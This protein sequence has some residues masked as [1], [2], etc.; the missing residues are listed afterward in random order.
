MKRA[1]SI[2]YTL[3]VL[4]LFC[5][6]GQAPAAQSAPNTSNTPKG[7]SIAK[8]PYLSALTID[9]AS[10]TVLFED[11]AD[12]PVYPAS[13]LKLMDLYIVLKAVEEGKLTLEEMVPVPLEAARMGGSQ[14]YLDPKEQFSVEEMLYALMVQ[15]ANDAATALAIHVA[16]S[17]AAFV[18]LMNATAQQLGMRNTVFHSEHGLPAGKGREQDVTTARDMAILCRELVKK[19]EALKYTSTT[20]RGFR[21]DS[22]IMRNHNHLLGQVPGVDGLKTGYFQ[23]AGFS[24]AATAEKNGQRVITLVMGSA[25]RKERDAKAQELLSQGLAQ[26]PRTPVAQS[27]E[28]APAADPQAAGGGDPARSSGGAD[29]AAAT[30]ATPAR[31]GDGGGSG[32]GKF[33][34]GLGAGIFI[35]LGLILLAGRILKRR[36][37]ANQYIRRR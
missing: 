29:T 21:N 18:D 32:W 20:T 14:V 22:F 7:Q 17:R 37:E 16:G 30:D 13:V 28:P 12:A 6:P 11:N 31:S 8:A 5:G 2:L 10:G 9:A 3:L 24:I 35:F 26:L 1:V 23:L 36:R 34:L 19:P 25:N 15:S 27:A 4:S 33:F